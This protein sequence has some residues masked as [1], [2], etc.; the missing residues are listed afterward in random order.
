MKFN[1]MEKRKKKIHNNL[2]SMTERNPRKNK[3][4]DK[5]ENKL[6][7][8]N[9]PFRGI[10]AAR[11][12]GGKTVFVMKN[13]VTN[14]DSPFNPLNGGS[15]IFIAPSNSIDQPLIKKL[16]EE[17]NTDLDDSEDNLF[18]TVEGL[19]KEEREE[20]KNIIEENHE[21]GKNT[22]I[23][24]DDFANLRNNKIISDFINNLFISGRHK[25]VSIIEILQK[26]FSSNAKMARLQTELF[27]LGRLADYS[28]I[29]ML[30][31]QIYPDNWKKIMEFYNDATKKKYGML[32]L[33]PTAADKEEIN[34]NCKYFKIMREDFKH[35]YIL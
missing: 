19:G 16:D 4:I 25:G 2:I 21:N 14:P 1:K 23:I 24:V 5:W 12:G 29:K 9:I 11:S 31:R 34:K 17:Y 6:C 33:N 18:I 8:P 22:L 20:I 15:I 7:M 32:V 10:V 27:V 3:I 30:T 26:V 13:F 28:D 35:S